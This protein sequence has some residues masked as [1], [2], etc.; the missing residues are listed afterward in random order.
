MSSPYFAATSPPA[1]PYIASCFWTF[2]NILNVE[3]GQPLEFSVVV[4]PP[5]TLPTGT[6]VFPVAG[7][8]VVW[9][10]T[11]AKD[12][13]LIPGNDYLVLGGD[14]VSDRLSVVFKPPASATTIK[15]QPILTLFYAGAPR[16]VSSFNAQT[17]TLNPVTNRVIARAKSTIE[18]S[19]SLVADNIIIEPGSLATLRVVTE[20][21]VDVPQVATS[22]IR[23]TPHVQIRGSIP[24]DNIIQA[25][26]APVSNALGQFVP[27]SKSTMTA[28]GL[29]V[30][31]LLGGLFSIPIAIDVL[32]DKITKTL[33]PTGAPQL[34]QLSTSPDGQSI[35]GTIPIGSWP[36]RLTSTDATWTVRAENPPGYNDLSPGVNL[37]KSFLLRPHMVPMSKTPNFIKPTTV[38]VT[39]TLHLSLDLNSLQPFDIQLP[40]VALQRMPFPVPQIAAVFKHAFDDVGNAPDQRAVL[41]TDPATAPFLS[42]VDDCL[43]VITRTTSVLNKIIA[44]AATGLDPNVW[45]EV[46]DLSTGLGIMAQQLRAIP[47][48]P[49]SLLF[50]PIFT[51]G[52][53]GRVILTGDWNNTISA[54][55]V[56]GAY[57]PFQFVLSDSDGDGWI[58]FQNAGRFYSVLRNLDG[59]FDSL[60]QQPPRCASSSNGALDFNDKLEALGYGR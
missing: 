17:Y 13:P 34:S 59:R 39:V 25:F 54:V 53:A 10:L 42:S 9:V 26:L 16:E 1:P 44:V 37:V 33:T 41:T 46:L 49:G 30:Q 19:L 20:N 7:S 51:T 6:V 55:A 28:A 36:A 23:E 58:Q 12:Q 45:G 2:P 21:L 52:N 43:D 5:L 3:A 38:T 32:G 8:A 27:G 29:Q 57:S 15:I 40:T 24:L 56:V 18:K 60:D 48:R 14:L 22:V 4:P 11:D 47:A 50:R 31:K 35:V